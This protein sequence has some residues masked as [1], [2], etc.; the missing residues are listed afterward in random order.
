MPPTP[1]IPQTAGPDTAA[2][3]SRT[4]LGTRI[5]E[6]L[7]EILIEALFT[8]V[9]VVLAFAVEEW[10]EE[11]ELDGLAAEARGAIL[12]EVARNRDELIESK[13]DTVDAVA[14]RRA[15]RPRGR[16]SA[17]SACSSRSGSR[18]RKTTR[19]SCRRAAPRQWQTATRLGANCRRDASCP[20]NPRMAAGLPVTRLS[21]PILW[22]G[23]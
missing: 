21:R 3:A 20:H 10:R 11:R 14:R 16:C 5:A 15:G 19:T 17:V 6:R 9:A 12:Q 18:S 22:E 13:Q 1:P 7:P 2:A 23:R 8:L 4:S